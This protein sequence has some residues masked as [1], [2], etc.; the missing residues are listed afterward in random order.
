MMKDN[1]RSGQRNAFLINRAIINYLM[2]SVLTMIISQLNVTI[3]GIIVSNLV[4]PDA[5]SAIN[6]FMPINIVITC[7]YTCFAMGATIR[8]SKAIGRRDRAA[9]RGILSTAV[10]SVVCAGLLL[11]VLG[12]AFDDSITAFVCRE[13]RIALYFKPY[14]HTMLLFSF[15]TI[16]QMLLVQIACIEGYPKIGTVS[17]V[18][19]V[20]VN[21][22]LDLLFVGVFGF[23]ITGSA[24]ATIIG[25]LIALVTVYYFLTKKYN[26]FKIRFSL[27]DIKKHFWKNAVQGLPLMISN[28][29]MMIMMFLLNNIVQSNLGADGMFVLSVCINVLSLGMMCSNGFGSTAMAIGGNLYGQRDFEG[30]RMLL[31]RCLSYMLIVTITATILIEIFPGF[32]ASIFGANSPELKLMTVRGIRIFIVILVPFCITLTMLNVFQIV[33]HSALTPIL[34]LLFPVILIPSMLIWVHCAGTE[35]LWYAFPETGIVLLL[36]LVIVTETIRLWKRPKRLSFL[37]LVP[38]GNE[39]I[40]LDLSIQASIISVGNSLPEIRRFLNSNV[41]DAELCGDVML[42]T[43]EMMYNIAIHGDYSNEDHFFDVRIMSNDN[44]LTVVLKDDGKPFD[45]STL[46]EDKKNFGLKIVTAFTPKLDY[47]FMYGQ[48]VTY[49]TWNIKNQNR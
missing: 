13:E 19:S 12:T 26:C 24:L 22:V 10:F 35:S 21:I 31:N 48:N 46:T 45:P 27:S 28:I 16:L 6:L 18:I 9:E 33:G 11:A 38:I 25:Y 40:H 29:I 14:M 32:L 42:S 8:A 20:S 3:D 36:V 17:C 41:K 5:L 39:E 15:I 34:A 2:A 47:K 43:E 7:I 37:T 4:S 44:E 23:G 30:L 1:A 49:M